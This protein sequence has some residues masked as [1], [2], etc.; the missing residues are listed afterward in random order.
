MKT[1]PC[2]IFL[3]VSPVSAANYWFSGQQEIETTLEILSADD[4][5]IQSTRARF[6]GTEGLWTI[7]AGIGVN[8]F[9]ETYQP[10]LFGT[11]ETL[12][13]QTQQ[14]DLSL[15]REWS[16]HWS[17]ALTL[18]AYDGYSD[19]RSV[20]I[21]E[22]Y[23]QLFGAFSGYSDPNPHGA[24]IGT[25]VTWNYLPGS[26]KVDF[27]FHFGRDEIAPGWGFNPV[28]GQPE[29]GTESLDTYTSGLVVEQ[30]I[31]SWL[32]TEISL[33]ARQ[34]TDREYRVSLKN[35]WA[36]TKGALAYRLS[37]GLSDERPSYQASYASALVEWNFLR[38]WSTHIGY[39]IYKDS[40]E[41][42][43]SGFDAL[44]PEVLSSELF[45]G[46]SWDRG[47]LAIST[48]VGLLQTDYK[49][50]SADNEFFGNLYRD[51]DWL[52]FRLSAA[53]KF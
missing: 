17:S 50:L 52:T 33:T 16:K 32:K 10:V 45:A 43:T 20:W 8:S 4:L 48:G 24:L 31:N 49:P 7:D 18:S 5:H 27:S 26:G 12:T 53:W 36:A 13:E 9:R 25:V 22:Y 35:S 41:I 40:G 23:R 44:A 42:Q 11:R 47:D 37:M 3:I 28:I 29:P 30:A 21:A 38:Q 34:T 6:S 15:S 19:Y 2:L 51:R 39:R 1:I 14:A 46:L